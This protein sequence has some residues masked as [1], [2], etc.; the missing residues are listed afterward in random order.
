MIILISFKDGGNKWP[1][2]ADL[3]KSREPWTMF[4]GTNSKIRVCQGHFDQNHAIYCREYR[5]MKQTV[6]SKIIVPTIYGNKLK[7][8]SGMALF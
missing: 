1:V 7:N 6:P 2:H 8:V 3:I 5:Q 4:T